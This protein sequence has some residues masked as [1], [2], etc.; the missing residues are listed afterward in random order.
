MSYQLR[1]TS[2]LSISL[3]LLGIFFL[4]QPNNKQTISVDN[5]LVV[6]NQNKTESSKV[7]GTKASVNWVQTS[8]TGGVNNGPY[9]IPWGTNGG[10]SSYSSQTNMTIDGSGIKS[11][12]G[13]SAELV[14]SIFDQGNNRSYPAGVVIAQDGN[15]A[16]YSGVTSVRGADTPEGISNAVWRNGSGMSCPLPN[17]YIQYKI[18]LPID[19]Y[20]TTT[21]INKVTF[22]GGVLIVY[23]NVKNSS[24]K[25]L[26]GLVTV[27]DTSVEV[28]STKSDPSYALPVNFVNGESIVVKASS[29]GYVSQTKTIT[30]SLGSDGCPKDNIVHFTLSSSSINPSTSEPATTTNPIKN[31]VVPSTFKQEG[32]TT[33][34]LAQVAD[35]AKVPNLTLDVPKKNKIVFAED[36]DLSSQTAADVFS[37]LDTYVKADKVGVVEVDSKAAAFLNKKAHIVMYNLPHKNTPKILVN[38][39][40]DPKIVSN[41]KYSSGI[42]NFDV[43]HFTKFEAVASTQTVA[44]TSAKTASNNNLL[45]GISF[46]GLGVLVFGGGY[47]IYRKKKLLKK[48]E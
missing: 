10:W 22:T 1:L 26:T 33:T 36:V 18:T 43:A 5:N 47:L 45:F 21:A 24:G 17:R 31:I 9:V 40:E 8:F 38:G 29:P 46:I 2:Y 6:S 42:L 44:T 11:S 48:T 14:S 4:I 30:M 34:D 15:P 35:P 7:L 13:N 27:K 23:G 28:S 19:Q 3:I 20:L 37:K 41:I 25:A 39:K 12:D 32:S 16:Y